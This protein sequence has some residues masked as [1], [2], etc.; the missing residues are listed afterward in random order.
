MGQNLAL[1]SRKSM[2]G[3]KDEIV[4]EAKFLGRNHKQVTP[5]WPMA[6]SVSPNNQRTQNC[7]IL[8]KFIYLSM[9]IGEKVDSVEQIVQLGTQT[10]EAK[11]LVKFAIGKLYNQIKNC[12]A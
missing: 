7:R 1:F 5:D 4:L 11:S 2:F 9:G 8:T 10:I 3:R 6:V 12:T